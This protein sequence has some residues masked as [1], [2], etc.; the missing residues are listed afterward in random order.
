MRL[1]AVASHKTTT[2][3]SSFL[4]LPYVGWKSHSLTCTHAP[5]ILIQPRNTQPEGPVRSG[6][7]L[8]ES[9]IKHTRKQLYP[10]AVTSI[11]RRNTDNDPYLKRNLVSVIQYLT[12][13]CLPKSQLSEPTLS[14]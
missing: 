10:I 13:L 14:L 3:P 12:D 8:T 7:P 2:D 5:L 4:V 6:E 11:F 9:I 1:F